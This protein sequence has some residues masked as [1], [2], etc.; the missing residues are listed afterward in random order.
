MSKICTEILCEKHERVGV[1][2]WTNL[3][4]LFDL[5]HFF[6]AQDDMIAF[7][8]LLYS[9]CQQDPYVLFIFTAECYF[10]PCVSS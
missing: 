6:L 2:R 9:A 7:C 8:P 1:H 4:S 10:K 3:V 5:L